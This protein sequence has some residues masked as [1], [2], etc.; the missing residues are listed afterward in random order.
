MVSAAGIDV[1]YSVESGRRVEL[2]RFALCGVETTRMV[3][4]KAHD[5][6]DIPDCAVLGRQDVK[7]PIGD[8]KQ[9][10]VPGWDVFDG[11]GSEHC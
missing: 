11:R 8:R 3:P 7:R 10:V 9:R 2:L 4:I 1:H 5:L 6:V